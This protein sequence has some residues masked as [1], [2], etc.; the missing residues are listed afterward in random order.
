MTDAE[1]H[2]ILRRAADAGVVLEPEAAEAHVAAGGDL[3]RIVDALA[4]AREQH[5]PLDFYQATALELYGLD[6]LGIVREGARTPEG[7]I[8]FAAL[9]PG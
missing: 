3:A 1:L 4:L 2:L 9:F 5:V 6:P 7:H 8:D